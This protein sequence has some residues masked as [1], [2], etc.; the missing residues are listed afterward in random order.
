MRHRKGFKQ[1]G[2]PTDQRI[3]ILRSLVAA[4]LTHGYV[5]T[6]E[7][8]AKEARPII[9]KVIALARQDTESNRRMARRW[10]PMGKAITT[11][12]KFENVHGEAPDHKGH[13]KK[14]ERKP[15]GEVLIDKLFVEIGPTYQERAGG[16]IRL[17]KLGGESHVSAKG[18]TIIRPA[19]RGDGASMVKIE[20]V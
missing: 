6:T 2:R 15:S 1:L 16:C 19:R 12:A 14:D 4:V 8:R 5:T 20:L 18:K 17:T 10:I 7:T 13:L 11:R 9:E 3:A